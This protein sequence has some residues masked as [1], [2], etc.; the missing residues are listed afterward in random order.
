MDAFAA[1]LAGLCRGRPTAAK[2]VFVPSHAVGYTL[3][4]RLVLEGTSWANLRF[5]PPFDLALQLALAP[6]L[7]DPLQ[8][9]ALPFRGLAPGAF[10]RRSPMERLYQGAGGFREAA[11]GRYPPCDIDKVRARGETWPV[12]PEM[13]EA[14]DR[15]SADL[16]GEIQALGTDLRGEIQA[17][18]TDLRGEIR[19]S[20]AETRVYVDEQIETTRVYADERIGTARV[21][22]DERFE[23]ARVYVDE[24]FEAHTAS[25]IH[26]MRESESRT[27]R[28]FDVVGES[29]RGEMRGLAELIGLSNEESV[30]RDDQQAGRTDA[31]ENRVLRLEVRVKSLEDDRKPRRPR[32][33]R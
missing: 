25:L 30:R 33:R 27:H 17:L 26:E 12:D 4:E 11:G 5:A 10:H 20:A 22:V 16:R 28:Y 32:R 15:F 21:Y 8:R 7:M 9:R 6:Y 3:G 18:G 14:F 24:R 1:Q 2:W 13:R 19:S 31:I 29:L 23:T